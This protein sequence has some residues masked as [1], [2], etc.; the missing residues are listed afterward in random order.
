VLRIWTILI[1]SCLY[2]PAE[3]QEPL[4]FRWNWRKA[5]APLQELKTAKLPAKEKRAIQED[6]YHELRS[7]MPHG[8]TE[9]ELREEASA[10]RIIIVD[11]TGDGIPEIIA[12]ALACEQ[13]AVLRATVH[14]GFFRRQIEN[15]RRF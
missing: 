6:I 2:G 15:M 9:P 1:D 4:P 10:T 14:F 7:H 5:D 12:K 8:A 11:V 3:A 13:A